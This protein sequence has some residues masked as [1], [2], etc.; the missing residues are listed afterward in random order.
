MAWR[1]SFITCLTCK[2]EDFAAQIRQFCHQQNI[3]EHASQRLAFELNNSPLILQSIPFGCS[4]KLRNFL[5]SFSHNANFMQKTISNKKQLHR[6][7]NSNSNTW[8]HSGQDWSVRIFRKLH[9][10]LY[11]FL[12]IAVVC[13]SA[14]VHAAGACRRTH[15]V[16]PDG[17]SRRRLATHQPEKGVY[18]R[19]H[20]VWS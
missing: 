20:A 1:D 19:E 16:E 12:L 11:F 6:D 2:S 15:Q 4:H 9:R 18:A 5:K 8:V 14:G 3:L 7:R 10:Y 13:G 17:V